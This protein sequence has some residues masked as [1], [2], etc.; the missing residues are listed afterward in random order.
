MCVCVRA[1]DF[2]LFW[3]VVGELGSE[4]HIISRLFQ[5]HTYYTSLHFVELLE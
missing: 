3:G 2:V 1:Q 4:K 5:K